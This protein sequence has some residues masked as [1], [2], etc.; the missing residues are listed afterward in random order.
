MEEFSYF[1]I[2]D[3][4]SLSDRNEHGREI[5]EKSEKIKQFKKKIL[6]KKRNI[7]ET[8]LLEK[9][10]LKDKTI[11]LQ[12]T[13]F[14]EEIKRRNH[15]GLDIKN[16]TAKYLYDS[17]KNNSC[18]I[19]VSNWTT[20]DVYNWIMSLSIPKRI[21]I[22][23]AFTKEEIDGDVLM[24][25]NHKQVKEIFE[26]YN[27]NNVDLFWLVILNCRRKIDIY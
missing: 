25:L 8:M 2:E 21:L 24:I 12:T 9:N 15:L 10:Q 27:L 14:E 18:N 16:Y 26:K 4:F 19:E 11:Q 22:A 17:I 20:N 5:A 13:L 1:S 6:E 3:Y 7:E 23:K